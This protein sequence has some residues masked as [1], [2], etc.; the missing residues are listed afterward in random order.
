MV[1]RFALLFAVLLLVASAVGAQTRARKVETRNAASVS[2]PRAAVPGGA[3]TFAAVPFAPGEVLS[4]DID[5]NNYGAAA[6]LDLSVAE[7]GKFF[8][9]DGLHL[10][11]DVKTVGLV[12]SLFAAVD[13]HSDSYVDPRTVLP[14]RTVRESSWNGRSDSATVTFD[15][16]KNTATAASGPI[17]IGP[18]TGDALGIIYRLRALPLKDGDSMTL[19]G[20]EGNKRMQ[21][22]ASVEGRERV[23][24]R[25]GE[26]NA[27]RVA[28]VP[29]RDGQPDEGRR[30][31]MFY[32]DDKAR[33]PVLITA[34]PQIGTIRVALTGVKAG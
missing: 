18:E 5:W 27:I 26:F 31:V 22:R 17:D 15:R 2:A 13:S 1:R 16:A 14:F 19:D 11:A 33:L 10:T 9:R 30:F 34:T 28:C 25:A 8:G 7:R 23:T 3:A 32:S 20:V 6:H 4:Y 12:R 21:V 24:T 29:L